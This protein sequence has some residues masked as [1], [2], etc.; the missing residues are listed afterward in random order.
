MFVSSGGFGIDHG[1]ATKKYRLSYML[2]CMDQVF[3][4]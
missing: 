4:D 2:L 3:A 1:K